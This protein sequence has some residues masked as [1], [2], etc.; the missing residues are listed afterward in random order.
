[1]RGRN[2]EKK[3]RSDEKCRNID[4]PCKLLTDS[5]LVDPAV[6]TFLKTNPLLN[7]DKILAQQFRK[8]KPSEEILMNIQYL[9]RKQQED[10]K[11]LLSEDLKQKWRT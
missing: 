6:K 5:S 1:M 11:K 2:T 8:P 4:N 3:L 9:C 7:C 10:S